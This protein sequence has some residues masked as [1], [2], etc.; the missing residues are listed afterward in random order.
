M[1][2]L[3]R[4]RQEAILQLVLTE[5]IATQD[6]LRKRLK[7]IGFDVTQATLSRDVREL[8]LYKE[9]KFEKQAYYVIPVTQP[10]PDSMEDMV[11]GAALR[12]DYAG[13]IAVIHCRAGTAAAMGVAL[14]S[15]HRDDV[16]GTIAGDDTVFVLFR[17]EVQA[18]DFSRSFA[19]SI[20]ISASKVAKSGGI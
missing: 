6:A 4:Q 18:R 16:V 5:K 14:D 19:K 12:T 10:L 17:S 11:H 9:R 13:N 1:S 15:L 20:V 7:M 2:P 8:H 3:K